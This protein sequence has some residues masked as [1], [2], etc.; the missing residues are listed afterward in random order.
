MLPPARLLWGFCSEEVAKK[1]LEAGRHTRY[2]SWKEVSKSLF[3]ISFSSYR[4]TKQKK[5]KSINKI[6]VCFWENSLN[7]NVYQWFCWQHRGVF[8][9]ELFLLERWFPEKKKV[10]VHLPSTLKLL[11]KKKSTTG[12]KF[13]NVPSNQ[14][15]ELTNSAGSFNQTLP[16]LVASC[17]DW[18]NAASS[19][20]FWPSLWP[21]DVVT[22]MMVEDWMWGDMDISPCGMKPRITGDFCFMI[23]VGIRSHG[24]MV[25][26]ITMFQYH[27]V[28]IFLICLQF[29]LS[30]SLSIH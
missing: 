24:K 30:L 16:P 18:W 8:S 4:S 3:M 5:S 22:G 2:G 11:F 28:G 23:F 13:Q 20:S 14:K 19:L 21:G 10:A 9:P 17:Q 26:F 12:H 1:R 25:R 7:H 6:T 15:K 29:H 27:L